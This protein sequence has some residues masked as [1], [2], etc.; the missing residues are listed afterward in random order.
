M[1]TVGLNVN[2]TLWE[3]WKDSAVAGVEKIAVSK[4][5][6]PPLNINVKNSAKY[7]RLFINSIIHERFDFR[8]HFF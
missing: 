5:T 3:D 2:E 4:T 6:I 8:N 7:V 1:L